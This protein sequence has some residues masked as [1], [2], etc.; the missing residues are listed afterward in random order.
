LPNGVP[1]Q[2]IYIFIVLR[3]ATQY[4]TPQCRKQRWETTTDKNRSPEI[5]KCPNARSS[6]ST[7]HPLE[8]VWLVRQPFFPRQTPC[9]AADHATDFRP[10]LLVLL[11]CGTGQHASLHGPVNLH[12]AIHHPEV[13]YPAFPTV[14]TNNQHDQQR[15]PQSTICNETRGLTRAYGPRKLP[16]HPCRRRA[17]Q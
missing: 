14:P 7:I 11:L 13:H 8:V 15:S 5:L 16:N 3:T 1:L 12:S 9:L 2:R 4:L 17:S 6:A 10:V